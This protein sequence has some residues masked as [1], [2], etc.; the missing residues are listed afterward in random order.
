VAPPVR[1]TCPIATFVGGGVPGEMIVA[2]TGSGLVEDQGT[3]IL[4]VPSH[5]PIRE[6]TG[7]LPRTP[8][9]GLLI[10]RLVLGVD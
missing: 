9:T 3:K 1:V 4:P 8:L 10:G 2:E 5:P 7:E 6:S